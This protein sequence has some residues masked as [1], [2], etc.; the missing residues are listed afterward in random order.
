MTNVEALKQ[1]VIGQSVSYNHN[2]DRMRLL[3]ELICEKYS[4]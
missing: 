3:H 2:V 4:D 1:F